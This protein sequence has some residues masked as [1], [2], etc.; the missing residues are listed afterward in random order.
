[1]PVTTNTVHEV[2]TTGAA[3]NGGGFDASVASPGTDYSQQAASQKTYTD[4]VVDPTTNTDA[5]SALI[6][7]VASDVGNVY[8]ITGG[9]G[10]TVQRV[11][12]MSVTGVI[13]RF[14]A[15]LGTLSSVG[16]LATMGGAYGGAVTGALSQPAA[17]AG[18]T[19]YVKAT[20][21]YSVTAANTFSLDGT[22]GNPI[23]SIGYTTTRT[24]GGMVTVARTSGNITMLSITGDY[25]RFYN[26]I[27]DGISTGTVTGFSLNGAYNLVSNC[28]AMNFTTAGFAAATTASLTSTFVNCYAAGG[29]AGALGGFV[30]APTASALSASYFG[31]VAAGNACTGFLNQSNATANRQTYMR[32]ISA[33][34]TGGT[35]HGFHTNNLGHVSLF[36]CVAYGNGGAGLLIDT[37]AVAGAGDAP[38]VLNSVFVN[39]TGYGISSNGVNLAASGKYQVLMNYNAFYNNTAGARLN[40]PTGD[41]SVTLTGDPFTNGGALD[42]SLNTTAG[43]G[44]AL[45]ATG[46]PGVLQAGGTGYLDI[47][48]LQ[49]QD[50]AG[51]GGS[52]ILAGGGL[53]LVQTG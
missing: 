53:G 12:L 35:Y 43:A 52:A 42:F 11:V 4:L 3:G 34:N 31:C 18:N 28:K 22:V 16:G 17:V 45:R 49:H 1:M 33:N 24:D 5:T 48:A 7:F 44:A 51:G 15:S 46:F 36:N 6:P 8:N 2:W 20:A 14:N 21:T 32:C 26:F 29:V 27:V 13:G 30:S 39:N 37:T 23:T 9:T 19:I 25:R 41:N 50:P 47:G 40:V 10:F 38:I